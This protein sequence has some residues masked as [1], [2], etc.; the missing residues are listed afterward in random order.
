MLA[1]SDLIRTSPV[2]GRFHGTKVPGNESSL[3]RKFHNSLTPNK[4]FNLVLN[5][6]F[7]VIDKL[8]VI[9]C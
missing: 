5:S 8:T 2:A 3:V 6:C 9:R 4:I 7:A 1:S